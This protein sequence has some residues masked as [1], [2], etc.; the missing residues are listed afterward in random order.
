MTTLP[1]YSPLTQFLMCRRKPQAKSL[2]PTARRL[3]GKSDTPAVKDML[4][5]VL[6]TERRKG[7]CQLNFD[8]YNEKPVPVEQRENISDVDNVQAPRRRYVW[9][10][11]KPGEVP[12]FYF[13]ACPGK[14]NAPCDRLA[15]VRPKSVADGRNSAISPLRFDNTNDQHIA[16]H[17]PLA[18][19]ATR[20]NALTARGL[21]PSENALSQRPPLAQRNQIGIRRS[22]NFNSISVKSSTA[23]SHTSQVGQGPV[24]PPSPANEKCISTPKPTASAH[25][26]LKQL[27]ITGKP[28]LFSF[29]FPR[30][31]FIG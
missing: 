23:R 7:I 9:K 20:E 28:G 30:L 5:D 13:R 16:L 12:G 22:L 29:K 31:A 15:D 27:K 10:S 8:I 21:T 14:R 25:S 18:V 11:A 17:K 6:N 26:A 1:V 24:P 3:F 4:Q 2:S 19:H